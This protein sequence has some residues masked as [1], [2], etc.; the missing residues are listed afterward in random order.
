MVVRCSREGNQAENKEAKMRNLVNARN[1]SLL[2]HQISRLEN[3]QNIERKQGD[4]QR[5]R[6]KEISTKLITFDFHKKNRCLP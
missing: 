5:V 4:M 3:R 2:F 1:T 6:G